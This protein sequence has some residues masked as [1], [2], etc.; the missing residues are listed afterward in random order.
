M[1]DDGDNDD[2]GDGDKDE[3]Y[4][5]ISIASFPISQ[6]DSE[7]FQRMSQFGQTLPVIGING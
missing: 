2:C 1:E 3:E 5:R 6:A 7:R 4:E